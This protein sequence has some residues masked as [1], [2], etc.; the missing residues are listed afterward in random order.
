M[1]R[2]KFENQL[3]LNE[4][5]ITNIDSNE[6]I[7]I[8]YNPH[9]KQQHPILKTVV[10]NLIFLTE[11]K[12]QNKIVDI[13]SGE[14]ISWSKEIHEIY[15]KNLPYYE[16]FSLEKYDFEICKR[17]M[18]YDLEH[19]IQALIPQTKWT[20]FLKYIKNEE[21]EHLIRNVGG[22]NPLSLR[23]FP[24]VTN[25][26]IIEATIIQK[27][28]LLMKKT[29]SVWIKFEDCGDFF[30]ENEVWLGIIKNLQNNDCIRIHKEK[31]SLVW[32][33]N[34]HD[35][36]LKK[37]PN[38][39]I[40]HDPKIYPKELDFTHLNNNI[41]NGNMFT[42]VDK[43]V[44]DRCVT[45]TMLDIEHIKQVPT[46]QFVIAYCKTW[47]IL[48][49]KIHTLIMKNVG[50]T[51]LTVSKSGK[52]FHDVNN[53]GT[54]V[55]TKAH[56]FVKVSRSILNKNESIVTDKNVE[57]GCHNTITLN[58]SVLSNN[59]TLCSN[60]KFDDIFSIK[61]DKFDLIMVILEE[62]YE[63]SWIHHINMLISTCINPPIL[64]IYMKTS[65]YVTTL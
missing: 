16:N 33:S 7:N 48:Y 31:V 58:T 20:L 45:T 56:D 40:N 1:F 62:D 18:M 11:I 52:I 14:R 57:T 21:Y 12:S 51:T 19:V 39:K 64:H 59:Y 41:L 23:R 49:G 53:F 60:C 44:D 15:F 30:V 6:S 36:Y 24:N 5:Q 38:V 4:W 10:Y 63:Q 32:A 25:E 2:A 13:I 55:W 35:E 9:F 8:T 50:S 29:R 27:L 42:S 65:Q 47:T 54:N 26:N 28:T 46:K 3:W 37:N 34:M 17:W 22:V 61:L 43:F